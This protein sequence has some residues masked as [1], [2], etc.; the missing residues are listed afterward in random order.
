MVA[1]IWSP[2]VKVLSP[3]IDFSMD[4]NV[5]DTID[6]GLAD[7]KVGSWQKLGKVFS[8]ESFDKMYFPLS[9]GIGNMV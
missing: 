1:I 2:R 4:V 8:L 6:N 5:D 3:T 7:L 9:T